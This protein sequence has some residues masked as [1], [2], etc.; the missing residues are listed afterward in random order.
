MRHIKNISRIY[1]SL[2]LRQVPSFAIASLKHTTKLPNAGFA[3]LHS[4]KS[5]FASF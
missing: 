3:L 4:S 1:G 2:A 5:H